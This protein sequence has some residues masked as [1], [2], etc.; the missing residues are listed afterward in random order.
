MIQKKIKYKPCWF[1]AFSMKRWDCITANKNTEDFSGLSEFAMHWAP[2]YTWIVCLYQTQPRFQMPISCNSMLE[3]E[4]LRLCLCPQFE[5]LFAS[6][7]H[8][9]T[10]LTPLNPTFI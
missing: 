10:I 7:K 9:Y 3:Q 8:A 2:V 1:L 6:R 5:S 4:Q